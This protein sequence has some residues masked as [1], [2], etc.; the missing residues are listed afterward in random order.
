MSLCVLSVHVEAVREA[1]ENPRCK[2]LGLSPQNREMKVLSALENLVELN[3]D[4]IVRLF[5]P[6]GWTVADSELREVSDWDPSSNTTE[7]VIAK[8]NGQTV[9]VTKFSLAPV[10]IREGT[11][12][13]VLRHYNV[14]MS[15]ACGLSHPNIVP[16]LM[17]TDSSVSKRLMIAEPMSE[18]QDETLSEVLEAH[19]LSSRS[20]QMKILVDVC[21]AMVCL[22]TA[23]RRVVIGDLSPNNILCRRA[24]GAAVRLAGLT[25]IREEIANVQRFPSGLRK[26]C[27]AA[28]EIREGRNSARLP[29]STAFA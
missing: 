18:P 1:I 21:K 22:H 4:E 15:R 12:D 11:L 25:D 27:S 23:N 8:F 16:I 7:E 2:A 10:N 19:K 29:M 24:G 6:D 5:A 20:Q 3:H 9:R 14:A 28:P 17:A 13:E 26:G